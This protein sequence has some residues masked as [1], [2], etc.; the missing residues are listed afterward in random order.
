MQSHPKRLTKKPELQVYGDLREITQTFATKGKMDG[1]DL[2]EGQDPSLR[3][4]CV[5]SLVAY[6]EM[7]ADRIRTDAYALA[8]QRQV[9]SGDAVVDIGTGTGDT[10]ASC[11]PVRRAPRVCV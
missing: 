7:V 11:L 3:I 9:K 10:C 4:A 6:G 5:Y 1:T 2:A 8:L